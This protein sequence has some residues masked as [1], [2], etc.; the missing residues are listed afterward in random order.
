MVGATETVKRPEV[1]PDGMVTL[2]D[3]SIQLLIVTAVPLSVA[4]L[5]P[6]IAPN[7]EP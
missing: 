2:M 1:A 4:T 6:C 7:P 5:L 3:V